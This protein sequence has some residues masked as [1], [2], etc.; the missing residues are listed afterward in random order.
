[1]R[2]VAAD[3]IVTREEFGERR[4]IGIASPGHLAQDGGLL[5][6]G[7]EIAL[8][9]IAIERFD[10]LARVGARIKDVRTVF[11]Y[12]ASRPDIDPAQISLW[13]DSFAPTN[14]DDF[15]FDQSA[16]QNPG[17]FA[18]RQSEPMGALVALLAGLYEDRLAAIAARGGLVSFLSVLEDRFCHV[19]QDVIVPGI[20]E[21]AD[22]ADIVAS[23]TSRP[24]LLE[25]FVDG[26][27]K[28][29]RD[30]RLRSEYAPALKASRNLVV[31]DTPG[32]TT[33]PAWFA[34]QSMR[35]P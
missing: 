34:E 18:Q 21:A 7:A 15:A 23:Q 6:G 35:K 29:A 33:L 26:R 9:D 5:I 11:H 25:G 30:A 19:P 12:L 3:L 32:E 16:M 10:E 2:G 27:N 17:P 20:L 4:R 22:I 31:R 1:V 28:L 14:S 24:I 13:G 8:V